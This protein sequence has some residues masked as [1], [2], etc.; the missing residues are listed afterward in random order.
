MPN[1]RPF[2]LGNRTAAI[3]LVAIVLPAI[4]GFSIFSYLYLYDQI[5]QQYD[6][7]PLEECKYDFDGDGIL[8]RI[9]L[10]NEPKPD[11]RIHVRLKL[12]VDRENAEKEVLNLKYVPIDNSFRTH[13]AFLE[14]S[15]LRKIVIYDT[16]NEHQFFVWNGNGFQ[17]SSN[18]SQMERKIRKA[19]WFRDDTGGH[20]KQ[21]LVKVGYSGFAVIYYVLLIS[22]ILYLFLSG[23]MLTNLR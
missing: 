7:Y 14:E 11:E 2:S 21:L 6:C 20:H 23:R 5:A 13:L 1:K 9:D 18:P 19:M 12:F 15:G 8:D 16:E 17:T 10:V 4:V 22:I 3:L